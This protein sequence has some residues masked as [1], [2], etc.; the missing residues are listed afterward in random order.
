MT[1]AG[2]VS[3]RADSVLAETLETEALSM[4]ATIA[5]EIGVTVTRAEGCRVFDESGRGYL[6]L[7]AGSGKLCDRRARARQ[8]HHLATHLCWIPAG[9]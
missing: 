2:A 9:H 7:T 8:L 4:T 5:R 3:E 1:I 6:D